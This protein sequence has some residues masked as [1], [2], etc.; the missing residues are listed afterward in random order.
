M[1]KIIIVLLVMIMAL[2]VFA[3]KMGGGDIT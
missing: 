1:K 3:M 2:P